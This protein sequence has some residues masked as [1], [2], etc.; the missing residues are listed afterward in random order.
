[1]AAHTQST[2][3]HQEELSA[4]DG[5]SEL[6]HAEQSLQPFELSS[7]PLIKFFDGL[8]FCSDAFKSSLL[9]SI[10]LTNIY[11]K[12]YVFF[13]LDMRCLFG[14]WWGLFWEPHGN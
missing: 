6:V 7:Q 4:G 3:P 12:Y 2:R 1:M 9:F 10:F 11:T 8:I 13:I 5:T 14:S